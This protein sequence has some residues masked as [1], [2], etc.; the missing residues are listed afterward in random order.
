MQQSYDDGFNHWAKLENLKQSAKTLIYLKEVGIDS[1]DE[2]VRQHSDV[3]AEFSNR[4]KRLKEVEKRLADITEL[5]KEIGTYGK[6]RAAWERYK[7]S[8]YDPDLFGV[9]RAD[10][11]LHKAAKNY[12]D[13]LGLKKL[14]SINSLKEK[15]GKLAQEKRQLLAGYKDLRERDRALVNAK[16]NCDKILNI[17]PEELERKQQNRAKSQAR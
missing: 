8:G 11:S 12:F 3:S 17:S 6:T 9:E 4:S 13:K 10:L 5:Q 2:L 14:P 1:Y 15:W 7:K 16:Y